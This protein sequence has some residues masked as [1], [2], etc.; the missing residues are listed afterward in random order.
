M[1]GRQSLIRMSLGDNRRSLGGNESKQLFSPT[2][3]ARKER[4]EMG[5]VNEMK[6]SQFVL[7]MEKTCVSGK[8]LIGKKKKSSLG[9]R[10]GNC[11][12]N[13]FK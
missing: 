9:E 10:W 13:I 5:M 7:K 6:I 12:S 3:S 11:Q 8:T 4:R 1:M 2:R